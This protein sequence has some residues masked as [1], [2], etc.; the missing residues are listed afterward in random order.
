MTG[1]VVATPLSREECDHVNLREER[2]FA[3]GL[4]DIQREN[5]GER[6]I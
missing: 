3:N 6:Y 1:L 4:I 2:S 5:R